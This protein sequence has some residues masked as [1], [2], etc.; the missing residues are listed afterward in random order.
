MKELTLKNIKQIEDGIYFG[1]MTFGEYLELINNKVISIPDI[2]DGYHR[3]KGV[4][5][6]KS[7]MYNNNKDL[8]EVVGCNVN[9]F[10]DEDKIELLELNDNIIS[11][12]AENIDLLEGLS[13]THII[14]KLDK[15]FINSILTFKIYVCDIDKAKILIMALNSQ[16]GKR[17]LNYE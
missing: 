11:I 14:S 6:S 13:I 15:R 7:K 5:E 4:V 1:Y 9:L 10:V 12:K 16:S 17:R 2:V 3:F 8:N